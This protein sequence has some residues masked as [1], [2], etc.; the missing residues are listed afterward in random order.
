MRCAACALRDARCVLL[1]AMRAYVR[2]CV[3]AAPSPSSSSAT[4]S[5]T[6]ITSRPRRVRE[7]YHHHT[8]LP[9]TTT[10]VRIEQG[11]A[12]EACPACELA[13]CELI[14]RYKPSWGPKSLPGPG[15]MTLSSV[16]SSQF[17]GQSIFFN[18]EQPT[19][20]RGQK[21]KCGSCCPTSPAQ[22]AYH[23]PQT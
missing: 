6:R 22:T 12:S 7:E 18:R 1:R 21:K 19:L 13:Y 20:C 4:G 10:S 5:T 8:Y 3:R 23:K 16:F 2:A 15:C 11:R 9:I 17:S 14:W